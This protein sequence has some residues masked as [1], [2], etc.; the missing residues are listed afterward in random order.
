[1]PVFVTDFRLLKYR[2]IVYIFIMGKYWIIILKGFCIGATMTVPGISGGTMA[3]VM[4]IYEDLL[5]AINGCFR[6]P[7]EKIPFL[8]WFMAGGA[9]GFFLLAGVVTYLLENEKTGMIVRL[10]FAAVIALGIPLLVKN[11]GLSKPDVKGV[12]CLIAGAAIVVSINFLP[13]GNM[14]DKD[15]VWWIVAQLLAG[16]IAGAAIILPGISITHMLY[17]M[18]MYGDIIHRVYSLQFIS[19]IPFAIGLISGIFIIGKVFE[20]FMEHHKKCV[21]MAITGFVTGAVVLLVMDGI[22]WINVK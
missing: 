11:S 9:A 15:G 4:G 19:L 3:V 17:I 2:F 16:V 1:M 12:F 22:G 5:S 14:G 10:V 8:L 7:K 20:S 18:G 21:Y 13:V 6:K